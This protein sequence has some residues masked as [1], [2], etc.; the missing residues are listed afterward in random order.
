[1]ERAFKFAAEN[2]WIYAVL[3]IVAFIVVGFIAF[4]CIGSKAVS[5]GQRKIVVLTNAGDR[6]V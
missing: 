6:T 2:P 1:M 4:L 3:V 5:T